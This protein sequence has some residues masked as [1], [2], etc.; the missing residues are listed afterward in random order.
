M[1]LSLR[2]K[3]LLVVVAIFLLVGLGFLGWQIKGGKISSRAD[4]LSTGNFSDV[5]PDY[6]AY[7]YIQAAALGKVIMGYPD[8]SF[9]P[10]EVITREQMA[11]FIARAMLGGDDKVPE[12]PG[13]PSF[14][15]VPKTLGSFKYIEY[16]KAKG[17]VGGYEDGKFHPA[18]QVSRDQMSVFIARSINVDP[19]MANLIYNSSFEKY[20]GVNFTNWVQSATSPSSFTVDFSAANGAVAVK[21]LIS[22]SNAASIENTA[23]VEGG[24]DYILSFYGKSSVS[25][26]GI[27]LYIKDN[28]NYCWH[29]TGWDTNCSTNWPTQNFGS[30]WQRYSFKITPRKTAKKFVSLRFTRSGTGSYVLGLDAVQL[31]KGSAATEYKSL[32]G[33]TSQQ[34]DGALPAG[35]GTA[36]FK[37]VATNYWAYKQIEYLA[38][39][40]IVSGY[41]DGT[42]HP[43]EKVTRAQAAVF[44]GRA[45]DLISTALV[46]NISGHVTT[47]TGAVL[48]NGYIVIDEGEDI[49]Q[50]DANGNYSLTGLDATT[51][52]VY[53]YDANGNQYES[54]DI[55][56]HLISPYYGD[57]K[58]D[59]LG[60]VKK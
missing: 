52:E 10:E 44:I 14:P 24:S 56:K 50:I 38:G 6:W 2:K 19:A 39:S 17:V 18:D 13:A 58:I 33:K 25:G 40:G 22:N 59:F 53:I 12:G 32:E 3:A 9:R 16:L 21:F 7:N 36:T 60:L 57:N 35:P 42:F 4:T 55:S 1:F 23:S 45:Y 5:K 49:A 43:T 11:T 54:P 29:T 15:D 51:F 28:E 20:S 8:G 41:P 34:I 30:S 26:K 37:D 27:Y 48:A 46:S 47:N 31:E